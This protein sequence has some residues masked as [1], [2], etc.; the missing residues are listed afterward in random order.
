ME[1]LNVIDELHCHEKP[2]MARGDYVIGGQVVVIDNSVP[3]LHIADEIVPRNALVRFFARFIPGISA[4]RRGEK[5]EEEQI[6][7]AAGKMFMTSR[8]YDYLCRST[9][10]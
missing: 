4:F 2:Y 1:S 3:R 9:P 6:I 10:R 5:L 8:A 7:T